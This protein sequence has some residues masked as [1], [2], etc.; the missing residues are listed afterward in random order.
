MFQF[1]SDTIYLEYTADKSNIVIPITKTL[2]E[3]H[4]F[5]QTDKQRNLKR[6]CMAMAI[7]ITMC[8][9]TGNNTELNLAKC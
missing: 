1:T 2:Q 6:Q 8:S 7:K 4:P 9:I 5:K 3:F